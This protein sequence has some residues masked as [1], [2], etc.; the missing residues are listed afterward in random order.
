MRQIYDMEFILVEL[1]TR[2]VCAARRQTSAMESNCGKIKACP[3]ADS[4]WSSTHS[5]LVRIMDV[6]DYWSSDEEL[7]PDGYLI[8]VYS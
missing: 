5:Q 6:H 7:D 2:Y 1:A 8:F 4:K 3:S